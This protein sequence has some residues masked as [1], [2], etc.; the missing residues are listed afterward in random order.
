LAVI[1]DR[2]RA[3]PKNRNQSAAAARMG[4]YRESGG[5]TARDELQSMAILKKFSAS[6]GTGAF[7]SSYD[8]DRCATE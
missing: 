1:N 8:P 2:A 4:Q 6:S 7:H 3:R 5:K